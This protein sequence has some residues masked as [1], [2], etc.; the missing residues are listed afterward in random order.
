MRER[1]AASHRS[2]RHESSA[3][4]R[5]SAK[6]NSS[7]RSSISSIPTES[8]APAW[9]RARRRPRRGS[10][11]RCAQRRVHEVRVPP[12]SAGESRDR[13]SADR[14]AAMTALPDRLLAFSRP[15]SRLPDWVDAFVVA[16]LC[17]AIAA[18]V[19]G[20]TP[21]NLA[22][23]LLSTGDGGAAQFI[24]KTVLEHG[25]Y[26]QNPDVGAPFGTTMYDFP[27]PEPTHLLLI[28][29]LGIFGRDPFLVFNLFYLSSFVSC[30]LAAWWGLR[31]IGAD[32]ASAFAGAF[33]FTLL[34]F[35][36]LRLG[37]LHLASYF[38]VPIFAAHA[39]RLALY[40]APHLPCELRFTAVSV[41][42][43]ALAAGIGRLLRFLRMRLHRRG[44]RAR[45][46]RIAPRGAA[47]HRRDLRSRHR[48][49]SRREP[50]SER[51]LSCARGCERTRRTPHR[52]GGRILWPAHRAAP[53]AVEHA[54][55]RLD[56]RV[57]PFI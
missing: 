35:H 43:L 11:A 34:P 14:E 42:L 39:T 13:A 44:R 23:P 4:A 17:V 8:R 28:R 48:R 12:R 29:T 53:A 20:V 24:I 47:A 32:R 10:R 27:I 41:L 55:L 1:L 36:F 30:A 22:V 37:H 2:C 26:T 31:F 38:A 40:R 56:E 57:H 49:G 19:F 25:W 6:I 3:C 54:P 33:L 18:C 46:A 50:R 7:R 16:A 9:R 45:G 21:S 15:L 51:A 52:A 5:A